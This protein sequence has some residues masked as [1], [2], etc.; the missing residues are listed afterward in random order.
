MIDIAE[1]W[2]SGQNI[3]AKLSRVVACERL[4]GRRATTTGGTQTEGQAKR[5]RNGER[6]ITSSRKNSIK[7][8]N[9]LTIHRGVGFPSL[10]PVT[11][12]PYYQKAGLRHA[13]RQAPSN[14]RGEA[15]GRL[16]KRQSKSY[17]H[18]LR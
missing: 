17:E 13:R 15:T 2:G 7:E 4:R 1:P 3:A 12:R 18:N 5:N 14:T 16:A 9:S 6:R 11:L 8:T 10:E